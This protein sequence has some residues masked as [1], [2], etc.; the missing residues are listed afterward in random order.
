MSQ[1]RNL[2][3]SLLAELEWL[4]RLTGQR[5]NTTKNV[6]IHLLGSAVLGGLGCRQGLWVGGHPVWSLYA[7]VCYA[8]WSAEAMSALSGCTAGMGTWLS[9]R[10]EEG[11]RGTSAILVLVL[12]RPVS[13]RH[14]RA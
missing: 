7:S 11:A 13:S 12:F 10:V 4:V 5:A 9:I 2:H 3:V 8:V 6:L 1:L 14:R